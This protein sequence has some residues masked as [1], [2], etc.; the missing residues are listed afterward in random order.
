MLGGK[1]ADPALHIDLTGALRTLGRGL[2]RLSG[3]MGDLIE[4]QRK[5]RTGRAGRQRDL[6]AD[7]VTDND[8]RPQRLQLAIRQDMKVLRCHHA[9]AAGGFIR[10][11]E[12]N[13]GLRRQ[14]RQERQPDGHGTRR[15]HRERPH[16]TTIGQIRPSQALGQLALITRRQRPMEAN[17]RRPPGRGGRVK[18]LRLLRPGQGDAQPRLNRQ[19]VEPGGLMSDVPR[20]CR[21]RF[22]LCAADG[23]PIGKRHRADRQ[24]GAQGGGH[25]PMAMRSASDAP[26]PQTL[27]LTLC[28]MD[29][30]ATP[31]IGRAKAQERLGTAGN[32]PN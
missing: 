28:P 10:L 25:H 15:R 7:G 19:V 30:E 27:H 5:L 29:A 9:K 18:T 23:A 6:N 31:A 17:A 12:A 2:G 11:E 4:A 14:L 3:A 1:L 8:W 22:P 20:R 13:L 21:Q 32:V 16:D 24:H 26:A